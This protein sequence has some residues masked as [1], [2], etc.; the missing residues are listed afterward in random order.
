MIDV[1]EKLG[2]IEYFCEIDYEN[3][4]HHCECG[5]DYC[6][7]CGTIENARIISLPSLEEIVLEAFKEDKLSLLKLYA[8]ER[9]LSHAG[10]SSK[11]AWEVRVCG[12]YYGE[13]I[14]GVYLDINPKL[15]TKLNA[16]IQMI[17]EQDDQYAIPAALIFEY[18]HLLDRLIDR[19]WSIID[20]HTEDVVVP[21]QDYF[22]KV[23]MKDWL[24][25]YQNRTLPVCVLDSSYRLVDGYHRFNANKDKK[26]ITVVKAT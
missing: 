2:N 11:D 25:D 8:I 20:L 15:L 10:I 1:K 7:R 3:G 21:N 14:D 17:I 6:C 16:E 18:G 4:R 24:F 19:E 5:D 12:G 22:R 23:E 9:V 26:K 13:E